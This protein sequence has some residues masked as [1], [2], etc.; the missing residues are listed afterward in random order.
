MLL[1][2]SLVIFG[3]GLYSGVFCTILWPW[4]KKTLTEKA[5][6]KRE[7]ELDR[8]TAQFIEDSGMHPQTARRQ[9]EELY[10]KNMNI[11]TP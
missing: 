3:A 4:P 6:K 10:M 11:L 5:A 2:P 1:V 9:A 8:L 7:G